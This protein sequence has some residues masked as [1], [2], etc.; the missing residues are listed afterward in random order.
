MKTTRILL[1]EDNEADAWLL[2]KALQESEP[3]TQMY[4]IKEGQA[5]LDF[6]NQPYSDNPFTTPDLIFLDLSLPKK[7]GIEVLQALKSNPRLRYIPVIILTH[8]VFEEE[9]EQTYHYNA[10]AYLTK[11]VCTSEV[12][13]II[14]YQHLFAPK[15]SQK[16][17]NVV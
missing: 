11:P 12:I 15:A 5:A 16:R 9:V 17:F 6:L 7:S 13:D 1:I 10:S 2:Q 8:T 4:L 3:D 14:K